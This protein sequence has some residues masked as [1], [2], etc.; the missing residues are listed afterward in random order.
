[1]IPHDYMAAA[2][3]MASELMG[4]RKREKEE[5]ERE[6]RRFQSSFDR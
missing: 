6:K 1:M 5:R 2:S 4:E 3:A